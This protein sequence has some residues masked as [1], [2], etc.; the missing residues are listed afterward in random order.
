MCVETSLSFSLFLIFFINILSI[1]FIY[2][3]YIKEMEEI[4]QRGKHISAYAYNTEIK[5][6]GSDLIRLHS[7]PVVSSFFPMLQVPDCRLSVKCVVKPWTGYDFAKQGERK[8]E[9]ELVYITEHGEVY[10][11]NRGCTYLSLSIDITTYED[12][13]KKKNRDGSSYT[14][15]DYCFSKG[16][17]NFMTAV[18]ITD[19][20]SKYHSQLK[21]QGLKRNILCIPISQAGGKAGC[22]KCG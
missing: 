13:N 7:N 17:E 1:S 20:G 10:H 9:E 21:C 22:S 4:H 14:A 16:K 3:T 18:Y 5:E 11:R 8:K 19:W 12:V 6:A 15:C 2:M